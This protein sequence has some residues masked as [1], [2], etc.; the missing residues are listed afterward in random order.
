MVYILFNL[1]LCI[2][3]SYFGVRPEKK[4]GVSPLQRFTMVPLCRTTVLLLL[5]LLS[6]AAVVFGYAPSGYRSVLGDPGM[7]WNGKDAAKP[8]GPRMQLFF[9][10]LCS[11]AGFTNMSVIPSTK[12]T[13]T[14]TKGAL[15]GMGAIKNVASDDCCTACLNE[16]WCLAWTYW[17]S[18]NGVGNC[19]LKDNTVPQTIPPP[20]PRKDFSPRKGN[21][22]LTKYQP[23]ENCID[24]RV[25]SGAIRARE[26]GI[27][28]FATCQAYCEKNCSTACT[29]ISY[30]SAHDDC[31]WYTECDLDELPQGADY[32]SAAIRQPIPPTSSGVRAYHHQQALPSPRYANCVVDGEQTISKSDNEAK[33]TGE[34]DDEWFAVLKEHAL[35]SKCALTDTKTRFPS[36]FWTVMSQN[37]NAPSSLGSADECLP[38]CFV[39]YGPRSNI[40]GY[41]PAVNASAKR[42]INDASAPKTPRLQFNSKPMNQAKVMTAFT[43]ASSPEL[44]GSFNWTFELDADLTVP[45]AKFPKDKSLGVWSWRFDKASQKGIVRMYQR[46]SEL[47]PWVCTYFGVDVGMGVKGNQAYDGRGMMTESPLAGT[48]FIV[49]FFLNITRD[50]IGG[51]GGIGSWYLLNMES[52]WNQVTGNNCRP[53]G[54][55]NQNSHQQVLLDYGGSDS[56]TADEPLG[57]P[58]YHVEKNGTKIHRLDKAHFPYDAYKQYCCP[59][60][61][62]SKCNDL[63]VPCCDPLSNSNGQS[64]YK[65]AP[66]P[67]WAVYGFPR[68]ATDGFLGDPKMH[69]LHVGKLWDQIWFPCPA[70]ESMEIIT[71]NIGPETGYGTGTHD[72]EFFLSDFDVLV[73]ANKAIS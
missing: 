52:C 13:C 24:T 40:S 21:C 66:H 60:T 1:N 8:L 57:C 26:N 53:Y 29:F 11:K 2:D 15:L 64:I 36:F 59:C 32:Y 69:E 44:I 34:M 5:S 41:P 68:N 23:P 20:L 10:N 47:Y 27:T 4:T 48:D 28:S 31:S 9:Y 63:N 14:I 67:I 33:N 18:P 71:L 56:C 16:P 37:G 55:T 73:P 65:I 54:N 62:C 12:D 42:C 43:D 22:G 61:S 6:W 19:D 49:R 39:D 17:K 7:R 25:G 70:T 35:A 3:G 50:D 51:G 38:Y 58:V 30:S 46:V 45:E 72:T